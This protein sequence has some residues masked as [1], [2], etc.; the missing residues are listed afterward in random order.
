M[1]LLGATEASKD[2]TDLERLISIL[3]TIDFTA[4]KQS[5]NVLDI[6]QR[7]FP[8]IPQAQL[9]ETEKQAAKLLADKAQKLQSLEKNET[10]NQGSYF[11]AKLTLAIAATVGGAYFGAPLAVK[12]STTALTQLYTF[13]FGVPNPSSLTYGILGPCTKF[14]TYISTKYGPYFFGVTA[15]PTVYNAAS[16]I[17]GLCNRVAYLKRLI[18]SD[19]PKTLP[20]SSKSADEL[21]KEFEE[22]MIVD[23]KIE[24]P[25]TYEMDTIAGSQVE[26]CYN[27]KKSQQGTTNILQES[28]PHLTQNQSTEQHKRAPV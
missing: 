23:S 26:I 15:G 2:I 14:L 1:M 27:Y 12:L 18:C 5:E 10:D 28:T 17:E 20:L 7:L 9:I 8:H 25:D 6:L 13:I 11:Y 4:V 3:T 19:K 22:L 21:V 16:V 24:E